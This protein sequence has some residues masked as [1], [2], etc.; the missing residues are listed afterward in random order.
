MMKKFD[1]AAAR[2]STRREAPAPQAERSSPPPRRKRRAA[3]E[4]EESPAPVRRKKKRR[5]EEPVVQRAGPHEVPPIHAKAG[6]HDGRRR[7]G[8]RQN[9]PSRMMMDRRRPRSGAGRAIG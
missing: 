6:R 4:E 8:A 2:A 9:T 3:E 7:A 5:E 1:V